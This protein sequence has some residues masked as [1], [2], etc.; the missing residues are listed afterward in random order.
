VTVA[1]RDSERIP[2][3]GRSEDF[4]W[5]TDFGLRAAAANPTNVFSA[6]LGLLAGCRP[7]ASSATSETRGSTYTPLRAS[8]DA[9][10]MTPEQA[11]EWELP[12]VSVA[13]VEGHVLCT[14][15]VL[16]EAIA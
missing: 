14:L 13:L 15:G 10:A 9:L 6:V 12:A 11:D 7:A 2:F 8:A 4:G 5:H 3:A 16:A 1:G